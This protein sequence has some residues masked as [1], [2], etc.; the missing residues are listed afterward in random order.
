ME[1]VE[2]EDQGQEEETEVSEATEERFQG[3]T[4]GPSQ[5]R[6]SWDPAMAG[7]RVIQRLLQVEQRYTPSALYIALAQR[8]PQHREELTKWALEVRPRTCQ[9]P[10]H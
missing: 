5:V 10:A 3:Q 8:N 2:Q 4:P 6:A 7:Q 1:E 9:P